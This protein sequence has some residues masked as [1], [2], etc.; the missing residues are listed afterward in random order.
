MAILTH[1]AHMTRTLNFLFHVHTPHFRL[2]LPLIV[3]AQPIFDPC[4]YLPLYSER[5][6]RKFL[7]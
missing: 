5:I 7:P 6:T 3:V 1:A 2:L 4:C